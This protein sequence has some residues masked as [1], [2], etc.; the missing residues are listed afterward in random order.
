MRDGGLLALQHSTYEVTRVGLT[1]AG[2]RA[3]YRDVTVIQMPP[4]GM[5]LDEI[6]LPCAEGMML[7]AF[8]RP[9]AHRLPEVRRRLR[10]PPLLGFHHVG[11][12]A[13]DAFQYLDFLLRR[14]APDDR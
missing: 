5:G 11:F 2:P 9:R 3:R 4:A 1:E 7:Y 8:T 13:K 12:G 14:P 6:P 10:D